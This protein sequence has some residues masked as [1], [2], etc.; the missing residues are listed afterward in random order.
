MAVVLIEGFD[1]MQYATLQRLYAS[2][3]NNYASPMT[4]PGYSGSGQCFALYPWGGQVTLYMDLPAALTY[5]VGFHYKSLGG[6]ANNNFALSNNG[7][8]IVYLSGWYTGAGGVYQVSYNGTTYNT[9]C[10]VNGQWQ[11]VVMKVVIS[12]TVGEVTLVVDG[13]TAYHATGL[14]LGSTPINQLQFFGGGY[15]GGATN[16]IDDVWVFDT[17][18]THS[19]SWPTG[20]MIVQTLYPTADGTYQQ[21]VPDSGAAHYSR[22]NEAI[23]DGDTSYVYASVPGYE[24]SYSMGSLSGVISNVHGVRGTTI[25]RKDNIPAKTL[26]NFVKSGSTVSESTD[27]SVTETYTPCTYI[28]TDDPNTSAQ[29]SVSGVNALEFGSKVIA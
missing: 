23:D 15:P 5:Y 24:D 13:A 20:D 14:N 17:T 22:V 10:P 6:G 29:W 19:N 8:G 25:S 16:Y 7:T 3:N 27:F 11:S 1:N 26:H 28:W 21:W 9:T 2:T 12:A 4:S 18:G